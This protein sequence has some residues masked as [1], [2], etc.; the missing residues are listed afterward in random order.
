MKQNQYEAIIACINYGAPALANELIRALN[1]VME[2]SNAF[3]QAK[4]QAEEAARKAQQEAEKEAKQKA[5]VEKANLH[6]EK[7]TKETK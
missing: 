6:I 7:K 5:E 3:I 1:Q 2:N 4:L